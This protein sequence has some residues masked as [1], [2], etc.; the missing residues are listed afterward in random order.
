MLRA[1]AAFVRAAD[2]SWEGL[3][4]RLVLDPAVP[5]DR[6]PRPARFLPNLSSIRAETSA[7]NKQTPFFLA[8]LRFI[9]ATDSL[10]EAAVWPALELA[11]RDETWER[12]LNA[13]KRVAR[14]R[15]QLL[16]R[17][18]PSG[19]ATRTLFGTMAKRLAKTGGPSALVR[20]LRQFDAD[21]A[22][23]HRHFANAAIGLPVVM[24]SSSTHGTSSRS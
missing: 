21:P 12:Y 6:R 18:H 22:A 1:Y 23:R 15:S 3:S 5:V 8:A 14:M 19:P 16:G 4:L 9:Y 2:P 7:A 24:P 17:V 10:S 20:Q 13:V 11:K